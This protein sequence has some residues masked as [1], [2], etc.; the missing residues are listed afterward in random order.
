MKGA[1][2]RWLGIAGVPIYVAIAFLAESFGPEADPSPRPLLAI[3][4]LFGVGC[5][6]YLLALRLVARDADASLSTVLLFSIV[7]RLILLPS[8]PVQEVDFYRYLWDGRVTLHGLNP[9]RYSPTQIEEAEFREA[10][11][12]DLAELRR[13]AGATESTRTIFDRVH[14]RDIPTA[15]PPMAQA[16]FA[17]SVWLTPADASVWLHVMIWKSVLVVFDVGTL[18][19]LVRLLRTVG[20]PPAWSLAYGW[21]PLALK[22]FANTGH[23]DSIAVFFATLALYL[24]IHA[25]DVFRAAL[26]LGVLALAILAKMYPL[27][28]LPLVAIYLYRRLHLRAAIALAV[29]VA[30]LVA[31]YLPF[32]RGESERTDT[33]H[34]GSGAATFLFTRWE[35]NDLLFMIVYRN[36]APPPPQRGDPWFVVVPQTTRD[37][38]KQYLIERLDEWDR[39]QDDSD[40]GPWQHLPGDADPA[41]LLALTVMGSILLLILLVQI[42]RVAR[43]PEPMVLL[44]ACFTVLAWGW[45]LSSTQNPWYVLWSLPLMPFARGRAWFLMPCLAFLYYLRFWLERWQPADPSVGLMMFDYGMVWLEHAVLLMALTLECAFRSAIPH[46][47]L[48]E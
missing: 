24:V 45:L 31:G 44:R 36:L 32:H 12:A 20:M 23:F 42:G 15:Y 3:L 9:Y 33:H 18:L 27:I 21:C 19:V 5:I 29:F 40:A 37:G 8:W 35:M 39:A 34:A 43:A 38:L 10:V 1:T 17:L 2:L 6:L 14:Y 7:Y 47:S 16:V 22:E 48:K 46:R 13:L 11:P 28:L 30:A 26:A 4:G 25:D 41:Y